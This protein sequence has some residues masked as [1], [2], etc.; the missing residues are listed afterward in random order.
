MTASPV[1]GPG[2]GASSRIRNTAILILAAMAL[3]LWQEPAPVTRLQAVWFDA[4]QRIAPRVVSTL[5]AVIVAIDD[6]SIAAFGQ[7]PWPRTTLARLVREISRARPA[8]I[9][10]D[11]LMPEPDRLS[12]E[13]LLDQIR[14]FD[15]EITARLSAL[16]STDEEL[17]RAFANTPTVLPLAA[18]REPTGVKLRA[19]PMLVRDSDPQPDSSSKLDVPRFDGVIG[20]VEELDRAASGR[21]LIT[22]LPTDGIIRRIPLIFDI[23]GTLAPALS[24]ELLRVAQHLDAF[25]LQTRRRAL[26][27][28]SVG[29][30]S[31]T[32]EDDGAVRPYYSR[33]DPRRFVSAV[34][35][36]DGKIDNERF[37]QKLVLI[38]VTGLGL[39]DYQNTPIREPMTG[40][41]VQA[42]LLENLLDG[43]L[44]FRP[45]WARVPEIALLLALGALLIFAAPR[46]SPMGAGL[47]ATGSIVAPAV[48]GY[49]FFRS[50]RWL[51]DA[52]TPGLALMLLSGALLVL[53]YREATRQKTLLERS[54][55]A[56]REQAARMAGE[57]EAAQRIQT[58][59]LPRADL[60][61]GDER[62]ELAA[63]MTPARE[64][65]GDLYD[66]FRLDDRR[67]FF[68]VGDVAGKGLSASIFMAVSK[69]LYKSMALRAPNADI[70]TLMAAA[71]DEVSRDNPDMLFVTAFAAILDLETGALSYCNAGHENPY[72][73]SS[74][75]SPSERI[76]DGDGPPLCVVEAFNYR[77]AGRQMRQ[78]QTLCC[79][80]DGV[81]DAQNS[82]GLLY[83]SG[84]LEA[85]LSRIDTEHRSPRG[86]VD[87]VLAD[88]GSFV[89]GAE[90]VDDLTVLALRWNGRRTR[91]PAY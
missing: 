69:A 31:A 81:T 66:F 17:A 90:T 43:T 46:W 35:V 51:F 7:W 91:P 65:G 79:V 4:Y 1:S 10:I 63:A 26:K 14:Q 8:T 30:W 42:Q 23:N 82:A 6:K 64:V 76:C 59:M 24:I 74:D 80:T 83:G 39:V 28:I 58:G 87:G 5:P 49:L 75:G 2:R 15:I 77:G 73:L 22:V 60:L 61:R 47:L 85:C 44:L 34:D 57:L 56:S 3:V 41:E 54:M 20:S 84:R 37:D 38:G 48:V 67:L 9:G 70:G 71:N 16:P 32:P 36:L 13:R 29:D 68:L 62:V 86:I 88:V 53:T 89:A 12:A 11:I 55:Q 52:A 19:A 21:G 27:R 72:V 33:R 25:H 45:T 40:T 78:G 50:E 18:A